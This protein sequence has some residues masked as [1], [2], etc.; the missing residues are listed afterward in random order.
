MQS[1]FIFQNHIFS[2]E[3]AVIPITQRKMKFLVVLCGLV[4][5][6]LISKSNGAERAVW[7]S[8]ESGLH[9]DHPGKCWSQ[10]LNREF[11]VGEEFADQTKCELN[12]C[13]PNFRF[14]RRM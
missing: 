8:G 14:S 1:V 10:S 2:M 5:C 9:P 6:F 13:G 7:I 11:S 3:F 4:L 12:R